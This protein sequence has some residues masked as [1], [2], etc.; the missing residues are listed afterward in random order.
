MKKVLKGVA[1]IT[2]AL[3]VMLP[4][5][6]FAGD[7]VSLEQQLTNLKEE[8][9]ELDTRLNDTEMHTATDKLALPGVGASCN[10]CFGSAR[11]TM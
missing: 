2:F 1:I 3:S 7:E 8:M 6:S 11:V 10:G 4:A 5:G 9:K